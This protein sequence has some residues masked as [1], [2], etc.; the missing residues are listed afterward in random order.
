[1][2]A[3]NTPKKAPEDSARIREDWLKRLSDLFEQVD[4]WAREIGWSTRRVEKKMQ[5]SEIGSYQA[6]ALL[7][8]EGTTRVIMEP[9]ARVAPGA[10]GVVDFYLLPAYDDI[11]SLYYYADGW[12]VHY[13]FPDDPIVSAIEEIEP[14]PL[15]ME[16]FKA[17]LEEMARNAS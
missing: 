6:P 5:D 2:A 10:E 16:A 9:I 8:Q 4:R 11:A 3:A 17:V 12:M 15:T 1:M 13:P 14:R 7:M